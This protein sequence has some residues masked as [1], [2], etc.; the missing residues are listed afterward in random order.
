MS[1]NTMPEPNHNDVQEKLNQILDATTIE[2]VWAL[3]VEVMAAFGFD[4]LLY[5]FTR[6]RTAHS[7]GDPND[8]L[9]LSNHSKAY[10]DRYLGEQLFLHGP[11]IRWLNDNTG[12]CSWEWIEDQLR[13]G[14]LTEKERYVHAVNKEMDICAGYSI[15]FKDISSRAKGAIGLTATAGMSQEHVEH[16]WR[17]HGP[18]IEMANKIMHL[19]ISQIPFAG[20][21]RPLTKRQ[22]EVLEWVADGKTT[23]DVAMIMNLTQATVEKHLRLARDVL[24]VETTAQAISKATV[25][26]QIF[27]HLVDGKT[28]NITRV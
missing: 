4:R 13:L 25:Q 12:S 19:K 8:I 23:Q 27:A 6:Y 20:H 10:I 14:S 24:D 3:H 26:N 22:K 7:Y 21:R 16:I 11:M 5:A 28:P 18:M 2:V 9:T 17:E 1:F 15:S